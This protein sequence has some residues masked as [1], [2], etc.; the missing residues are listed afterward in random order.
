MAYSIVH[1]IPPRLRG[2]YVEYNEA[3]ERNVD[4]HKKKKKKKKKSYLGSILK[5]RL[6]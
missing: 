1:D 6:I 4:R 3:T 2:V 5:P